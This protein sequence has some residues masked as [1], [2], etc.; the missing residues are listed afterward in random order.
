MNVLKSFANKAAT[1]LSAK[2]GY[3]VE[4]DTDGVNACNALTDKVVGVITK[5]AASG[6]VS[7]VCIFGDCQAI[8]GGTVKAGQHLTPHTDGTIV[9]TAASS[10]DF[11]IAIEDGVAGDWIEIFIL[12]V[13]KTNS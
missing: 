10:Q 12:G 11:A 5:G 7:E 2:D 4:F 13:S 6:G 3:A 1:D 9:V 8:L